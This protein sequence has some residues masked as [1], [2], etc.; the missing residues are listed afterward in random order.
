MSFPNRPIAFVLTASNHGSM[1]VNRN[2]YHLVDGTNGYGVGYQILS[3]SCFD[4]SEI[5]FALMLLDCRR[6]H[7]GDGVVA[8]DGGANIGVHSIEWARHMYGWGAVLGFEAQ[9]IVYYALAGN[10]AVNNCLNARVKLAALGEVCGELIVPQ[11]DY[12]TPSSYG[13]L[14]LRGHDRNEFIGQRVS[15][16]AASGNKVPMVNL[17]S[18]GLE[19]LDLVKLDVE[20]MELEALRGGRSVLSEQHPAM[21]IEVIKSDRV[22]IEAFLTALDYRIFPAGLNIL[23][24]H[25]TDPT[26]QQVSYQNGMTMLHV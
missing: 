26:L 8:I 13:S 19:R 24:L 20:G 22:A 3:N 14:E 15:Y 17:D 11:P 7:F 12:F 25:S 5:R 10:V 23:A 21:I 9:E 4:E 1:I 6:K 2:D 16:D 18:L